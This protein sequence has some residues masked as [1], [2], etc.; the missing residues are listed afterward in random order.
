MGLFRSE[1]HVKNWAD[2]DPASSSA[3]MPLSDWAKVFA[4]TSCRTRLESDTLTRQKI[5]S[6]EL[7]GVLADLGRSGP[8][9]Q[10]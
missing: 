1:D 3:T 8:W 4:I 6:D 9:W 5:F 2:Y 7:L 10:E